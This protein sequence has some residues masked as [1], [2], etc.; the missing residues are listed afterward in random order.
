MVAA[1]CV[2]ECLGIWVC[3]CL[4]TVVLGISLWH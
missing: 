4:P 2:P 1:V 3:F